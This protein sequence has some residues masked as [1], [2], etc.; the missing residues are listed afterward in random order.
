MA[1]ELHED[2]KH[3]ENVPHERLDHYEEQYLASNDPSVTPQNPLGEAGN[4][5]VGVNEDAG[6]N[7]GSKRDAAK[8]AEATAAERQPSTQE[9]D[10]AAAKNRERSQKAAR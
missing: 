5:P 4:Q 7:E 2:L 9:E 8:I 6:V 1:E 10:A 3:L